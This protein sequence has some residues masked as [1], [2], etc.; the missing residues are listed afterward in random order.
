MSTVGAVSGTVVLVCLAVLQALVA[1]GLPLGRFVWGGQHE[2]LP[3][4]LRIGS[5]LAI[6]LYAGVSAL[7]LWRAGLLGP[8]P[9]WLDVAV[10]VVVAYFAV[11]IAMNA[12]SRSRP[13]R[14]VMTP[15]CVLLTACAL[16]VAT[17]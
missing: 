7:L 11:G 10:W 15:V 1:A 3:R 6:V 2:V 13:E 12:I 4:H 14:L 5:A 17:G 9:T 8:A 16:A